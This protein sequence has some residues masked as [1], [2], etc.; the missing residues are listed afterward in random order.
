MSGDEGMRPGT[1]ADDRVYD[2]ARLRR[3]VRE[4]WWVI[5]AVTLAFGLL[6][7]GASL[8]LSPR[9]SATAQIAYAPE[10]AQLAS[11]ALSSAGTAGTPHNLMSDALMM[12]T[13]TFGDRVRGTLGLGTDPEKLLKSVKITPKPDVDVIEV[14]AS[15]GDRAAAVA[16]A[17]AFA[18]QFVAQRQETAAQALAEAQ[19]LV[20]TRI[21]SL[22]PDEKNSA[23]GLALSQRRDDLA[24]L[25]SMKIGD[26]TILERA[27]SPR[28]AYFP[29][30]FLNLELGL[31]LGLILGFGVAI[32]LDYF[33]PRVKDERALARITG[34][35]II[36]TVPP[37][38]GGAKTSRAEV[39]LAVGFSEGNEPVLEAMRMLRSNLVTLGLGEHK[40]SLLVTSAVS[41]EGKSSLAANLG[42]VMA[43]SG[44][45]VVLIDVDFRNP[46]LH[47]RLGLSNSSGLGEALLDKGTWQSRIQTV[48]LSRFVSPGMTPLRSRGE[49]LCLTSGHSPNN[50]SELLESGVLGQLITELGEY[51]D[52]V[53]LDGPPVLGASDSISVAKQVDAV[54][55][56]A[57]LG[58]ETDSELAEMR[59]LLGHARAQVLGLVV[60]GVKPMTRVEPAPDRR[61]TPDGEVWAQAN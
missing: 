23:Y 27:T 46:A 35:P 48:R 49:F 8:L 43:F 54:L 61:S 40:R 42:L 37:G 6:A 31:L 19:K 41:G 28:S 9:Y 17:N 21:E 47:E 20:Q 16:L 55:I 10:Q 53:I 30:P 14:R 60:S 24:V 52:T 2:F 13:L 59:R 56:C 7:F 34:L 51:A 45:R 4:R 38:P 58:H 33:D 12:S 15:G 44:H 25:V 26:Y 5:L 1:T 57:E 11:Q 50:A 29:R 3:V 22:T 18:E 32:L 36:G 39:R